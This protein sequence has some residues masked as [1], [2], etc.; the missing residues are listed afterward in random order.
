MPARCT[1]EQRRR[2]C[3][4]C[5]GDFYVNPS[6]KSKLC[7]TACK[8]ESIRT[9]PINSP[10]PCVICAT[11]FTPYRGR[12]EAKFCSKSCIGKS[13]EGLL[14]AAN[15]GRASASRRGDMMR[16]RG[17]L[18]TYRKRD[19]Q[20]EHRIIAAQTLG[21]PLQKGEIVHHI[22]GNKRNNLPENLS[23]MTQG[24]HMKEHGLGI[25]G[26]TLWWKPWEKRKVK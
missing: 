24:Q 19:G 25:A 14:R 5:S 6:S 18:R 11:V 2:V 21:R 23:V 8:N 10:R 4:Q 20:H 16:D 12:G 15:I 7:S 1:P 13:P 17:G 26:M 3:Q 22:D 9:R